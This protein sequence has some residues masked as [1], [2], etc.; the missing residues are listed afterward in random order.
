MLNARARG[1]RSAVFVMELCSAESLAGLPNNRQT[2]PEK[3]ST[4]MNPAP[5]GHQW[6][7]H[8]STSH[9]KAHWGRKESRNSE[10]RRRWRKSNSMAHTSF[11]HY[12]REGNAW[13]WIIMTQMW[14]IF[15]ITWQGNNRICRKCHG[16]TE[17]GKTN[18]VW[19]QWK[20]PI[21]PFPV[22][23]PSNAAC[24]AHQVQKMKA[25]PWRA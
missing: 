12:R 24:S 20:E 22:C 5:R 18:P 1:G 2:Y 4:Q 10:K 25:H 19:R 21:K 6:M 17:K 15:I 9:G 16:A 8:S 3:E 13:K 23:F 7:G 14:F 11:P